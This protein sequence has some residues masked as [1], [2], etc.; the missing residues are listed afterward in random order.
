MI[1]RNKTKVSKKYKTRKKSNPDVKGSYSESAGFQDV[2]FSLAA[3]LGL[4]EGDFFSEKETPVDHLYNALGYFKSQSDTVSK[5][6]TLNSY[7]LEIFTPAVKKAMKEFSRE[8]RKS[9]IEVAKE[10]DID[11]Y[12][13]EFVD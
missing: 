5:R 11:S 9:V 8:L 12:T 1:K 6:N 7:T 13:G 10:Y 3:V 4:D 2:R